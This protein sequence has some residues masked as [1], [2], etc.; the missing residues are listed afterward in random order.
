MTRFAFVVP[1]GHPAIPGHFPG[2][3]VVPGVVLL[4]E[5]ARAA[6]GALA[7]G[8]LS[9][10]SRVKFAAP[11]SPGQEVAVEIEPRAPG[12]IGFVCRVGAEVVAAGEMVFAP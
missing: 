8:P 7:L 6:R 5:V 2:R 9:A 12:R 4:D 3:P 1:A 10:V 11:V